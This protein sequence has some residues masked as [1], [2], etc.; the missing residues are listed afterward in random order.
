MSLFVHF[1]N[2]TILWE[3]IQKHPRIG[4]IPTHKRT[5]WFKN[6]IRTIYENIPTRW[7]ESPL[8]TEMLNELNQTTLR[9]MMQDLH[10]T[11]VTPD[12]ES[13]APIQNKMDTDVL[14]G[15]ANPTSL[16]TSTIHALGISPTIVP[17][18]RK[19]QVIDTHQ[20]FQEKK[21]EMESLLHLQ[22][23]AHVE[24][25]MTE[26]DEPITN[27]EELIQRQLRQREL[28]IPT[29]DY[30]GSFVPSYVPDISTT[31]TTQNTSEKLLSIH[32]ENVQ[33][34]VLDIS[35]THP[36]FAV[37]KSSS[38]LVE[39]YASQTPSY[40]KKVVFDL[41]TSESKSESQ[42]LT[43]QLFNK[44]NQ[45]EEK[46][47]KL[48]NMVSAYIPKDDIRVFQNINKLFLE[49]EEEEDDTILEPTSRFQ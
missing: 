28:D 7:F 46:I 34:N 8:S 22:P 32:P 23:P 40:K 45:L 47:D 15:F 13:F 10:P 2:Q 18:I 38:E 21:Q 48:M 6:H 3:T 36:R 37:T 24:F 49:E 27:M 35:Q 5:T 16:P 42:P 31:L 29:T 14:S 39:G 25:K 43:D 1:D 19:E 33:I 20:L 17:Q 41:S 12:K 30:S 11:L 4:V 44:M 9:Q 26:I